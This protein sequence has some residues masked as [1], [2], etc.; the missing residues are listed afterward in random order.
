MIRTYDTFGKLNLSFG[1]SGGSGII[2]DKDKGYILKTLKNYTRRGVIVTHV[3]PDSVL[4]REGLK[5]D[6]LIFKINYRKIHSLEDYTIFSDMLPKGRTIPMRYYIE[7]R[8]GQNS[9]YR[10][11]DFN[12]TPK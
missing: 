12:R 3:I 10:F 1:Y 7:R 5:P 6:D 11:I 4:G 9:W 8:I 2:I